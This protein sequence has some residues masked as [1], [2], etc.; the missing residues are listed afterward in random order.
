VHQKDACHYKTTV[1]QMGSFHISLSSS[2]RRR[3][4]S[5]SVTLGSNGA[6]RAGGAP[7]AGLHHAIGVYR[8]WVAAARAKKAVQDRIVSSF[9]KHAEG[10]GPE[11][12]DAE[13]QLFANLAIAGQR[14]LRRYAACKVKQ[15]SST[16]PKG[17][18]EP[19]FLRRGERQ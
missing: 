15:S 14:L 8:A 18:G 10:L 2:P 7:I 5:K 9:R 19:N 17:P 13:L 12:A 16:G 3:E 11:P 1:L 6:A 4:M